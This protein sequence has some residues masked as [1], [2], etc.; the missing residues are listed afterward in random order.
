MNFRILFRGLALI[1]SLI[2][3]GIILKTTEFGSALDKAWIDAVVSGNGVS[4]KLVFLAVGAAFTGIGLPRQAIGF[5]GGY[6]F[7]VAMGTG[8]AV[9]ATAFGCAASFYYAR[10]LGREFVKSRYS[11]KIKKVDDFLHDNPLSMTLLIRLLPLGS[12]FVTNLAAGVS[13][14][15]PVPFIG[16][17]AIGYIPQTFIFALIGSG[18]TLQPEYRISASIVLFIL[19]GM[20]GVYLYRKYRHGKSL[21]DDIERELGGSLQNGPHAA[22]D[23]SER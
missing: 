17:S 16:G 6:A 7:G 13:S 8:L 1:A 3:I 19:S 23:G 12:N 9:V 21:D 18:I 2:A 14:V 11:G 15:H 5:L 4:G 22:A 20:L 10:L